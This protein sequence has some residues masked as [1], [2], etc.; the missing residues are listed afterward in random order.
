MLFWAYKLFIFVHMFQRTSSEF[1]FNFR[2]SNRKSQS[3][4]ELVEKIIHFIIQIHST[5]L[6]LR[7]IC[8]RNTTKTLSG[9]TNIPENMFLFGVRNNICTKRFLDALEPHSWSTLKANVCIFLYISSWIFVP[10]T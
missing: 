3:Q 4:Q 8:T 5:H 10:E 6:T 7:T 1:F 9:F 2:F